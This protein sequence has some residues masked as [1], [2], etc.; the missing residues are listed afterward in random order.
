M[1]SPL[2][3]A[4]AAVFVAL[5]WFAVE[6]TTRSTDAAEVERTVS[7]PTKQ[8]ANE[9]ATPAPPSQAKLEQER[10]RARYLPGARDA[11]ELERFW[12]ECDEAVDPAQLSALDA[13]IQRRNSFF[14][15]L[16]AQYNTQE[17]AS[18]SGRAM[19]Q[20]EFIALYSEFGRLEALFLQAECRAGR[21]RAAPFF[22]LPDSVLNAAHPA[23][24]L[25]PHYCSELGVAYVARLERS[26]HPGLFDER[27]R[28]GAL[29]EEVMG[30]EQGAVNALRERVADEAR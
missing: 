26:E 21:M 1:K 3:L 6:L 14:R 15:D 2:R 7:E 23:C 17:N 27:P 24:Q 8:L 25:V 19:T 4:S 22:P 12:D 5:G 9:Q 11:A 20:T 10:R 16:A 29:G 18:E 13:D 28:I 30:R